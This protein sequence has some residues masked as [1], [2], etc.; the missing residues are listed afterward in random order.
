MHSVQAHP[1]HCSPRLRVDMTRSSGFFHSVTFGDTLGKGSLDLKPQLKKFM[2][3]CYTQ[4]HVSNQKV[5]VDERKD[6]R[7]WN[8]GKEVLRAVA[9]RKPDFSCV[10]NRQHLLES[11]FWEQHLGSCWSW[12]S[13][14]H[15]PRNLSQPLIGLFCH[16]QL[17]LL[18]ILVHRSSFCAYRTSRPTDNS[19]GIARRCQRE[20]PN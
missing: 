15:P 3:H 7:F 2:D 13:H 12:W 10:L 19:S 1:I 8:C 18:T 5:G 20:K 14:D 4:I 16:A 17:P 11:D 6:G 9:S